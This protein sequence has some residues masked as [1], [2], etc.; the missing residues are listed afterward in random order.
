MHHFAAVVIPAGVAYED[1]GPY[2]EKYMEPYREEYDEAAD[3]LTGFWDWYQ[4]GG[5]WTGVWAE[6]DPEKDPR[7]IADGSQPFDRPGEV[8]WPT[9]WAPLPYDL[10]PVRNFLAMPTVFRRPI[11]L[12]TP[13]QGIEKE[14]WRGDHYKDHWQTDEQW[15]QTLQTVLSAYANDQLLVVDYHS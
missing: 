3:E 14:T 1:A 4:I 13:E 12:I 6:Y 7:N 5:R 15:E 8:R 2:V 10:I 11:T 9:R